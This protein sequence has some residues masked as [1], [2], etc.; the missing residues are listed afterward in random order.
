MIS[1][2][3]PFL[4][5]AGPAGRAPEKFSERLARETDIRDRAEVHPDEQLGLERLAALIDAVCALRG[6]DL[7]ELA[8]SAYP[9]PF[10]RLYL[11]L[12]AQG[13]IRRSEISDQVFSTLAMLLQVEEETLRGM[14]QVEEIGQP[15]GIIAI[16]KRKMRPSAFR[17][18]APID[19]FASLQPVAPAAATLGDGREHTASART[20]ESFFEE[21]GFKVGF[22]QSRED[23]LTV[24]VESTP[25]GTRR[26][27]GD[28]RVTVVSVEDGSPKAGPF[29]FNRGRAECGRV[30]LG[31]CDRLVLEG[32]NRD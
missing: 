14:F 10:D 31:P 27:P 25:D 28:L 21:T 19:A 15:Q 18:V 13:L 29:G 24:T 7:H 1:D 20:G 2:I 23:G 16:L 32:G 17:L 8:L 11:L 3:E 6:V 26:V 30:D 9:R 22:R 12:L 5:V 4:R